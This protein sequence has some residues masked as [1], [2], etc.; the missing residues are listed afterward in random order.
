MDNT[1]LDQLD[2]LREKGYITPAYDV[3]AMRARTQERPQWAHFGPGNIFRAHIAR[4]HQEILN[5]NL[6]DTGIIAFAGGGSETVDRAYRPFDNL[7]VS[8]SLKAAGGMDK[9]LVA[10]VAEAH[11]LTGAGLARAIRVFEAP[12]LQMATFTITEKG[13]APL[14]YAQDLGRP[15][16]EA[17]SLLGQVTYLL[18]RRLA[19]GGGGIA[20]VSLD[21][22]SQN[23]DQLKRAI[24]EIARAAGED[25]LCAYIESKLSFP[26]TMIDKITPRPDARVQKMLE[27]DGLSGIAPAVTPRGTHIAPFVNAEEKE[28][29]VI[30]DDFPAGR[31]PLERAGVYFTAR[32]TVSDVERMKVTVCLNPLHTALAV[33]GCLLDYDAIWK[34]THDPQLHRLICKI[35]YDEGLPVAPNPGIFSPRQFLDE[36]IGDRLPNPYLPDTPQRIATDT[37]Q[38]VPIRFGETIKAHMALGS[39]GTLVGIPLALAGWLRYLDGTDDAGMPMAIAD[40]PRA[41]EIASRTA[42]DV[43][44]DPAVFGADLKA[45]GLYEKTLG[46]LARMRAGEGAVRATLTEVLGG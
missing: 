26:W 34:E 31:P 32:Q 25:A 17:Q 27:D 16:E 28:Y 6:Y 4:V 15:L 18:K 7:C 35:G 41:A 8:V 2:R 23:G 44:A 42:E 43:L 14:S 11:A 46:Y 19:A 13:Y 24:L 22:C 3:R 1:I 12:T 29:L 37:S 21:N 36:V 40:D 33:F 20:L 10:S 38:K 5:E 9:H 30:E 45:A 39:A